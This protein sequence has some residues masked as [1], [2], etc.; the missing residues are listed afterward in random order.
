MPAGMPAAVCSLNAKR[1]ND[2][3]KRG[4]GQVFLV[5]VKLIWKLI[6]G[7]LF[8]TSQRPELI[9]RWVNDWSMTE[10]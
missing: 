8:R 9:V 5:A 1:H 2:T 4:V 3:G 10:S 6:S 7:G